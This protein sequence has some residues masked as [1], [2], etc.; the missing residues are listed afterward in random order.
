MVNGHYVRLDAEQDSVEFPVVKA[1]HLDPDQFRFWS[2]RA[3]FRHDCQRVER[4]GQSVKPLSRI[5]CV[6]NEPEIDFFSISESGWRNLNPVCHVSSSVPVELLWRSSLCHLWLPEAI[7]G[8][9][10]PNALVPVDLK[11]PDRQRHP[12]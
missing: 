1:A 11:V 7:A 9:L 10:K 2:D 8:L 4:F 3:P 6:L 5:G 12:E